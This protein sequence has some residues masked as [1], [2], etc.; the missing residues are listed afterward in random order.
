MKKIAL[1]QGKFAIVD[2][3]DYAEDSKYKWYARLDNGRV[4]Y[5][6]RGVCGGPKKITLGMHVFILGAKVGY[7]VDHINHD[8]LDNRKSNLRHATTSQNILNSSLRTD[9]AGN[10]KGVKWYP[11]AKKWR[12][13]IRKNRKLVH[14][15]Y[16]ATR[17]LAEEAYSKA[18]K[19]YLSVDKAGIN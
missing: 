17:E 1:T 12:A 5:A 16:F 11:H 6:C 3:A 14:L 10:S 9:M 4:W 13:H 2:E 7:V 18:S 8:G 15:G 19:K